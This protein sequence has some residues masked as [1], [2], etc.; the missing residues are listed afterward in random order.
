MTVTSR[1]AAQ[2]SG[3]GRCATEVVYTGTVPMASRRCS[4]SPATR[5]SFDVTTLSVGGVTLATAS[6]LDAV[7]D[8]IAATRQLLWIVGPALVALVAGLAWLLAGRALRPVH[9]VTSRVAAIGSARC[10][11]GCRCRRRTTRS[12]SW[13]GR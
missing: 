6:S 9:A 5:A 4:A 2:P 7:R 8:T 3:R 11:S 13:P 12:P 1:L 10:T